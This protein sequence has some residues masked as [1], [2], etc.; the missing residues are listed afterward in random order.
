MCVSSCVWQCAA[1]CVAVCVWLTG[2]GAAVCAAA[3]RLVAAALRRHGGGVDLPD[4]AAPA[5]E[6]TAAGRTPTPTPTTVAAMN[7]LVEGRLVSLTTPFGSPRDPNHCLSLTSDQ[8]NIFDSSALWSDGPEV[9]LNC[10][11]SYPILPPSGGGVEGG[12]TGSIGIAERSRA[13][14]PIAL[15]HS[16]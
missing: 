7:R 2:M 15:T 8:Y 13:G 6:A 4:L 5:V 9:A 11:F 12:G 16:R 10:P 3:C 14:S 1:V